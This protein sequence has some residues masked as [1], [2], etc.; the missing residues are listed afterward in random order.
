MPCP[1]DATQA[2]WSGHS[3]LCPYKLRRFAAK[4]I[5]SARRD[6]EVHDP[7]RLPSLIHGVQ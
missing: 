5:I 4:T 1:T 7:T 2:R 3:M 6:L